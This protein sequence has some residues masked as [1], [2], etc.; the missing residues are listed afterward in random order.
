[1]S[2]QL[3]ASTP[4]IFESDDVI[5]LNKPA[6][7]LSIEDGYQPELPNLRAMLKRQYGDIWAVHRL[8]KG[9]SG[10]ILFAKNPDTHKFFNKQFSDRKVRKKY[11]AIVRGFPLWEEKTIDYPLRTNGDHKHRTVIDIRSGKPAK[12]ILEVKEKSELLSHLVVLPATGYTHQIRAHCA[13]VGLPLLG[14]ELYFRG[15]ETH[16]FPVSHILFLH[17]IELE[18]DLKLNETSHTFIAPL[19]Q[20]FLELG[21]VFSSLSQSMLNLY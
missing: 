5:V 19:P 3:F 15:C 7:L 6:G 14:D 10:V 11:R 13:A 4:V 8:D 21:R 16:D 2:D 9:T 18:I 20:H 12:T 1:V 17:A